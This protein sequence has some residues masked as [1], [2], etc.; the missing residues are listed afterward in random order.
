MGK[1]QIKN[2]Q[3][4]KEFQFW[5]SYKL[6]FLNKRRNKKDRVREKKSKYYIIIKNIKWN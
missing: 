5:E 3:K 4:K 2:I 1:I 6:K